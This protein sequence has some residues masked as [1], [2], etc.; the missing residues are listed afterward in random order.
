VPGF[1]SKFAGLVG[2]VGRSLAE[3]YRTPP[4]RPPPGPP[5]PAVAAAPAVSPEALNWGRR[6]VEKVRSAA[7]G[8]QLRFLPLLDWRTGETPEIRNAYRQ[9]Q[10]DSTIKAALLSKVHAVQ[11]LEPQAHAEDPD[12]PRQ[13]E[14]AEFTAYALRQMD[15]GTMGLCWELLWHGLLDGN[16]VCEKVWRPGPVASGRWRGKR[17]WQQVKAKEFLF[18]KV[19]EFNNV[20]CYY[21]GAYNAGHE[22][23]PGDFVAWAHLPMFGSP[24]GTSDLRA[25]YRAYYLKDVIWQMRGLHLDKYTGPYLKG[26]YTDEEKRPALEAALENARSGTWISVPTGQLVEAMSLATGGTA[27]YES[28]LQ[29]CDR[30]MLIGVTF[31]YLQVLEGKTPD[32][33]GDTSV[34]KDV[35]ELPVWLLGAVMGQV[36]T[37]HMARELTE[38]NYA[39]IP[40]ATVTWG[41][42][43][44]GAIKQR[45]DNDTALQKLGFK[46]SAK[47][48]ARYCGRSEATD[49]ADILKPTP[50]PA[51]PGMPGQPPPGPPGTPPAGGGG[52]G[53]PPGQP[54]PPALPGPKRPFPPR[55]D[56][57]A[58][59]FS[60]WS[61]EDHPRD[62]GGR[63]GEGGGGDADARQ[64]GRD[65]R[66]E[67]AAGVDAA[68]E[69]AEAAARGL[70]AGDTAAGRHAFAALHAELTSALTKAG[71]SPEALGR[72]NAL[73]EKGAAALG[74]A[75]E[76]AGKLKEK[77]AALTARRDELAAANEAA[78]AAYQA[79]QEAAPDPAPDDA[80]EATQE[81][82]DAAQ[83][84]WEAKDE[85]LQSQAEK[86]GERADTA[87][88]KADEAESAREAAEA[89][90]SE[91]LD[92][93]TEA[94]TAHA[95]TVRDEVNARLDAEDEADPGDEPHDAFADWSEDDHPRDEKG[96][97]GSGGGKAALGPVIPATLEAVGRRINRLMDLQAKAHGKANTTA[98][99]ATKDRALAETEKY[100]TELKAVRAQHKALWDR[101]ESKDRRAARPT[102]DQAHAHVQHFRANGG[103]AAEL[104]ERLSKMTV[105]QLRELKAKLG[106]K[107]SGLKA[108]FVR[109]ISERALA[110][111]KTPP[112]P[113]FSGVAANGVT[114][115]NGVA[116]KGAEGPAAQ[117]DDLGDLNLDDDQ[118]GPAP[119]KP[120]TP[121]PGG[122]LPATGAAT[123]KPYVPAVTPEMTNPEAPARLAALLPGRDP[124]LVAAAANATDGA[125]VRFKEQGDRLRVTTQGDGYRATR[126]FYKDKDGALAV[127][128]EEFLVENGSPHDGH[129]LGLFLNQ[130]RALREAGVARV[131]TQASG[132]F[133]DANDP[134]YPLNGYYTWARLGYDGQMEEQNYRGLPAHLKSALGG[135]RSV[136][137][138]MALPGGKEAWEL[139]G[140]ETDMTFDLTPGS[141]NMKV[142]GAY[143]AERQGRPD[144]PKRAAGG[145]Q[146]AADAR[147][148]ER[149]AYL[150]KKIKEA[151]K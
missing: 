43:S 28:A 37:E 12:D 93:H 90:F 88:E 148:E 31:A 24:M 22:F 15:G 74:K 39:G 32:G 145:D 27:D 111:A 50:A 137:D 21:G 7:F 46:L 107:A 57:P 6:V 87:V 42:V 53:K 66:R 9:M 147:M 105:A 79:H 61:E 95:A 60:D 14:N 65:A 149:R 3:G 125:R 83:E 101:Q 30:E 75:A 94:V 122:V 126:Q 38:L 44:E 54:G 47:E 16:A 80:D 64:A 77:H 11:A 62:A 67:A 110:V 13:Q 102:V 59:L 29:D 1:L 129:G 69:K 91:A 58:S 18:P 109:K 23:P 36:V 68:S 140:G 151:R 128:N 131:K 5:V 104:A 76:K 2:S 117:A 41:T 17:V 20:R 81:K 114:F 106:V 63:F 10:R 130:V 73:A 121:G 146:D 108:E 115:V 8:G 97:F 113:G 127:Y 120:A 142:L 123:D 56:D 51:P 4:R 134:E 103:S 78:A 33:R 98:V 19:D 71:A 119:A 124:S 40:P 150:Q 144:R 116:Q 45:L 136:Q 132:N 84:K 48:T 25:S 143:L 141:R 26:T 85:K 135:S 86:A 89:D 55:G 112:E 35:S 34:H 133:A 96:R 72:L 139:H 82:A 99:K 100:A 92:R 70:E 49:P 118:P 138:L 52:N